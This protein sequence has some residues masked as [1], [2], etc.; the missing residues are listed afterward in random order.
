MANTT[1]KQ[2]MTAII[3]TA[4][5]N[6]TSEGCLTDGYSLLHDISGN[7]MS[8]INCGGIPAIHEYSSRYNLFYKSIE[9]LLGGTR[10]LELRN[11]AISLLVLSQT[12]ILKELH[13]LPSL[14][15]EGKFSYSRNPEDTDAKRVVTTLGRIAR[16]QMGVTPAQMRD[17]VIGKI[18]A[19]LVDYIWPNTD[20]VERVFGK[21][22]IEAY[23]EYTGT[24]CMGGSECRYVEVYE[25]NEQVVSL[26]IVN[27]GTDCVAK[28]LLWDMPEHGLYL[29]RV[30]HNSS[31]F[32]EGQAIITYARKLGANIAEN[33]FCGRFGDGT[34]AVDLDV[35]ECTYLPYMDTF[36]N[37]RMQEKNIL[38]I[39]SDG[40]CDLTS[41]TGEGLVECESCGK[42]TTTFSSSCAYCNSPVASKGYCADCEEPCDEDD[43]TSVCDGSRMV[44]SNCIENYMYCESCESYH[45]EDDVYQVYT[46]ERC[47]NVEYYCSNCVDEYTTTCKDCGDLFHNDI[48]TH[49]GGEDIYVCQACLD[50]GY[51]VC[52]DCGG[53]FREDNICYLEGVDTNVCRSCKD[54]NY[55]ECEECNEFVSNQDSLSIVVG[56]VPLE[57]CDSCMNNAFSECE[58]C[59]E[60]FRVD[61]V[62]E[63][64]DTGHFYCKD[65]TDSESRKCDCCEEVMIK[66]DLVRLNSAEEFICVSCRKHHYFKCEYCDKIR[67]EEDKSAIEGEEMCRSCVNV[68]EVV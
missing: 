13:L 41:T 15:Q 48:I 65:C 23:R 16:R 29:D 8:S 50:N 66:S 67:K 43:L 5:T 7:S 55:I 20:K 27:D 39:S 40:N 28:A 12:P 60:V 33:C 57:V 53:L 19:H 52:E 6:N 63:V 59:K 24:S 46:G 44:C 62:N 10:D 32:K 25:H 22:I 56:D 61:D 51:I 11:S 14:D 36:Q 45:N 38:T 18:A 31:N 9:S 42:Q 35:D 37:V 1:A 64:G 17:E 68:L 2:D 21:D 54:D 4:V 47:D 26:L 58:Y 49:V 3:M 30:Y 34:Y